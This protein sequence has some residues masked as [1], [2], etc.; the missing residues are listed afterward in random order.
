MR[1]SFH[2]CIIIFVS[3]IISI[4]LYIV[5]VDF[6]H[7]SDTARFQFSE[8]RTS[9]TTNKNRKSEIIY[10]ENPIIDIII[11]GNYIL[12]LKSF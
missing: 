5:C 12:K 7:V 2:S 6:I 9:K 8:S 1:F 10:R 4:I 11:G 3:I